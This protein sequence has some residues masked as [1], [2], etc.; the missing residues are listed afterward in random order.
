MLT[1]WPLSNCQKAFRHADD[2]T[3]NIFDSVSHQ[4]MERRDVYLLNFKA[5]PDCTAIPRESG[6]AET[7]LNTQKLVLK[8]YPMLENLAKLKIDG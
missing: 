8:Q 3:D 7:I 4:S 1:N 2:L 6:P 5:I